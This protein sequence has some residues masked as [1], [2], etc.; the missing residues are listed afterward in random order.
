MNILI[1]NDD[2][3]DST[4][5]RLLAEA[6][7]EIGNVTVVAPATE[8][9]GKSV[10][11]NYLHPIRVQE[12]DWGDKF[13][14]WKAEGSPADCVKLALGPLLDKKPDVILSGINF[15]SNSGRTV[16]YSGT[17]GGAIEGVMRGVPSIAFSCCQEEGDLSHVKPYLTSLIEHLLEV[18]FHDGTLFN[19]NFPCHAI[20]EFSGIKFAKQ[21]RGYWIEKP[22][23]IDLPGGTHY[24]L[25]GKGAAF[26]EDPASDVALLLQGYITAVPIHISELTDHDHYVAH[27]KTFETIN[28]KFS[29]D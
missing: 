20:D 3:I 6:A 22:V 9:S 5:L 4:G 18:D 7:S 25:G 14:V 2:S 1:T 12:I 19:V 11:I 17:V 24:H 15:G 10:G 16:L 27:Q 23:E 26:E 13:K 21:G 28:T 29:F 8:Q